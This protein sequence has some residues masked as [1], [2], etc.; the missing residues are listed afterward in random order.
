MIR[1]RS[2][3]A[4]STLTTGIPPRL[5]DDVATSPGTGIAGIISSKIAAA[6]P[7]RR[8]DPAEPLEQLIEPVALLLAHGCPFRF[9][10]GLRPVEQ[11]FGPVLR[12]QCDGLGDKRAGRGIVQGRWSLGSVRDR[13]ADLIKE[14]FLARGRAET[15][16][17]RRAFGDVPK[18][19][20]GVG[21]HVYRSPAVATALTPRNVRSI[22]PS[23]TVN[24]SSKSWR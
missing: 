2:A 3:P 4:T 23:R 9:R 21:R 7:R 24:I 11:Q 10:S 15:Q 18:H 17:S 19:V 22:S 14:L 1:S 13:N 12:G 6:R 16:Q 20:R 8:R 5:P